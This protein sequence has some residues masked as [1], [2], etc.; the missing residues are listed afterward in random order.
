MKIFLLLLVAINFWNCEDNNADV[1]NEVLPQISS[2]TFFQTAPC[3]NRYGASA[4]SF[5][6]EVYLVGGVSYPVYYN[7][8]SKL[9]EVNSG[10]T[11]LNDQ[12]IGRR[13]LTAEVVGGIIYIIGG[14]NSD[15]FVDIVQAF[16]IANG[17]LSE[18]APLPTKRNQLNSVV[19]NNKI[20]VIGGELENTGARTNLV[21]VYDPVSNSWETL[22]SMPTARE[23]DI[24][25]FGN[26]IYAFGGF[27]GSNTLSK[28]EVYDIT[29][30]S[31]SDRP[32]MPYGLSA[33]HLASFDNYIFLFGDY[34]DHMDEVHMYDVLNNSMIKLVTNFT[35]R[36]HAAVVRNADW[37]YV[38]GGYDGSTVFD[39]VEKCKPYDL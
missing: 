6:N 2:L 35:G 31:W 25:I 7:T 10:W 13:Y 16:D 36:R 15:G 34:G 30:N 26:K 19:Y 9:D 21:E 23:C 4:V 17:T 11:I 32:D 8:I 38:I 33:Y 37:I 39:L 22:A 14:S 5:E 20:Y 18:V 29:N 1:E 28:V 27:D 3:P 24:A 12:V